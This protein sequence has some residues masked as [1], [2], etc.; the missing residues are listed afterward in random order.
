L[1]EYETV[2]VLHPTYEEKEF[3]AEVQAVSDMITASGGSILEIDR[4]GR[5]RLAYDINK[6][7]EGIYTLIRY[8]SDAAVLKDLER[9]FRMNERM[10]RYMTVISE[11]PLPP[12]RVEGYDGPGNGE[13]RPRP[14][15]GDIPGAPESAAP[16]HVPPSIGTPVPVDVPGRP[17]APGSAEP[18]VSETS[19]PSGPSDTPAFPAD[20]ASL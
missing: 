12:P 19:A 3:E 20:G 17:D 13:R 10:L 18:P 4:W 8:N 9:R 5:R 7:H 2:F 1:R 15:P 16:F 6:V 14:M 11:G